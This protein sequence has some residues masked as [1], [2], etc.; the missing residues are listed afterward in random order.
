ML[1]DGERL[2]GGLSGGFVVVVVNGLVF[3]VFGSDMGGSV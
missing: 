3:Y 2:S 1:L